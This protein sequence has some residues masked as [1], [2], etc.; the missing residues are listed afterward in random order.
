MLCLKIELFLPHCMSHTDRCS[1]TCHDGPDQSLPYSGLVWYKPLSMI[2]FFNTCMWWGNHNSSFLSHKSSNIWINTATFGWGYYPSLH[3]HF[4]SQSALPFSIP[5]PLLS[6]SLL[7]CLCSWQEGVP[8]LDQFIK[9][10]HQQPLIPSDSCQF[11]KQEKPSVWGWGTWIAFVIITPKRQGFAVA[12][13]SSD[14]SWLCPEDHP[15]H[16]K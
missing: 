14:F 8:P 6:I 9:S 7:T 1:C 5:P 3:A 4:F 2:F 10:W 11:K 13:P 16:S 12:V 15:H